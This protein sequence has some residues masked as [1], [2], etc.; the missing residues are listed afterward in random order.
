MSYDAIKVLEL[1]GEFKNN[2]EKKYA[3]D[4]EKVEKAANAAEPYI[5]ELQ[6]LLQ[7]IANSAM[8]GML[9]GPEALKHSKEYQDANFKAMDIMALIIA[10]I[11]TKEEIEAVLP[12]SLK[13]TAAID[14]L[15]NRGASNFAKLIK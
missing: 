5:E 10:D 4:A 11:L 8:L 6:E 3:N 7:G 2:F 1:C 13:D 12:K 14:I 9:S 15:E